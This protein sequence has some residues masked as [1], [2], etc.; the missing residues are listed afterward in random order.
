VPA[1]HSLHR[2][3]FTVPDIGAAASFYSDFGLDARRTGERVDLYVRQRH[4]WAQ[5]I[6]ARAEA[7][8]VRELR[9]VSGGLRPDRRTP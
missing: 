3:V 6:E 4:R 2:F 8:A 7:P 9:R 1:V 5:F